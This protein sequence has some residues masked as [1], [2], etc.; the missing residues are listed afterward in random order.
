MAE[1]TLDDPPEIVN[2]VP[3]PQEHRPGRPVAAI[4][5]ADGR[6]TAREERE[7]KKAE[8]AKKK[9]AAAANKAGGR[10]VVRLAREKLKRLKAEDRAQM[11]AEREERKAE[12]RE[13]KEAEKAKRKA[14]RVIPINYVPQ[15]RIQAKFQKF[16]NTAMGRIKPL[17]PNILDA[18]EEAIR[19]ARNNQ[20]AATGT[21]WVKTL[22]YA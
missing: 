7:K 9:A 14:E 19:E 21:K 22:D 1:E 13:M 8:E 12:D 3:T 18:R 5:N 11:K 4:L 20:R 15:E 2:V 10:E 16:S 6:S 17:R